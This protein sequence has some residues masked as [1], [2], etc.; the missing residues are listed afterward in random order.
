MESE[1]TF[2]VSGRATR[3]ESPGDSESVIDLTLVPLSLEQKCRWT[4]PGYHG[5][6]H[7]SCATLVEKRK[8]RIQTDI[9][10]IFHHDN[11]PSVRLHVAN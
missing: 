4:A 1:Q 3:M 8:T 11:G 6:D 7:C 9:V 2:Y 5:S 10:N